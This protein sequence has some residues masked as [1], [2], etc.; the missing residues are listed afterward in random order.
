M[1]LK[2][3]RKIIFNT[4][5][6]VV[7][8]VLL[9]GYMAKKVDF[10]MTV[11]KVLQIPPHLILVF[12]LLTLAKIYLRSARYDLIFHMDR[13]L[14]FFILAFNNLLLSLLPFKIGELS[15]PIIM[16]RLAN[17]SIKEGI[18]YLVLT[19]A[20]DLLVLAL[21]A[22]TIVSWALA[23]IILGIS[24][25]AAVFL[26][27]KKE[28]ILES[29]LK[30]ILGILKYLDAKILFFNFVLTLLQWLLSIVVGYLFFLMI[31]LN[32]V[33][34][35]DV[36]RGQVIIGIVSLTPIQGVAGYGTTQGYW[37]FAYVLFGLTQMK[38]LTEAQ[39]IEA[40]LVGQHLQTLVFLAIGIVSWLYLNRYLIAIKPE[41]V[42]LT[43]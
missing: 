4:T 3:N 43:N 41:D 39:I 29:R 6:S 1:K 23:L 25:V 37:I 11:E 42:T 5:L 19:R 33:D 32:N 22:A 20:L 34:M 12:T 38:N 18:Q 26:L 8:M 17:V 36:L 40:S 13:V 31:G 15:T 7:V 2:I 28:L 27:R 24:I 30:N 14:S 10:T 21:M 16:K 35:I 9:L